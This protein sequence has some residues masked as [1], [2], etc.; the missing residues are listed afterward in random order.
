MIQLFFGRDDIEFRATS[1]TANLLTNPR[2]YMR[3]S[4]LRQDV[5]DVRVYQGIHFRFADEAGRQQGERIGHWV[6][7]K[8]LRPLHGR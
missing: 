1:P 5:V 4:D 6:T 2:I 3:L 8:Y 7:M